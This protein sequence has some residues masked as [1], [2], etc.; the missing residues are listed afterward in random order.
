MDKSFK[1][2]GV[3]FPNEDLVAISKKVPIRTACTLRVTTRQWKDALSD[4]RM[5][6]L[7]RQNKIYIKPVSGAYIKNGT[8]WMWGKNSFGRENPLTHQPTIV[9]VCGRTIH[10]IV[11]GM[12]CTLVLTEDK[13]LYVW[14]DHTHF[15]R[16]HYHPWLFSRDRFLDVCM[17]F[18][19]TFAG[20][21]A[22]G[23]LYLWDG[24]S[25]KA[26]K[27]FHIPETRILK[28]FFMPWIFGFTTEKGVIYLTNYGV[29]I[30]VPTVEEDFMI[31]DWK[32][33][34]NFQI[35]MVVHW[36]QT[37][38]AIV[39]STNGGLYHI[40]IG[41]DGD[42]VGTVNILRKNV[43]KAIYRL[44]IVPR[45]GSFRALYCLTRNGTLC[46]FKRDR[47]DSQKI[48]GY[49]KVFVDFDVTYL[50]DSGHRIDTID[51]KGNITQFIVDF[52]LH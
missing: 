17:G 7:F 14:G 13:Q 9:D 29:D 15:V 8:L 34:L 2:E 51:A 49:G 26:L 35:K 23:G 40:P 25:S 19:D 6:N 28:C 44:D 27:N 39:L 22:D 1:M 41:C 52:S 11:L 21:S 36:E 38:G 18:D 31:V 10:K 42:I 47:Y 5:E 50:A 48:L 45:S 33:Q 3:K 37:G 46:Y 32:E 24:Q 30:A 4:S 43:V 20:V 16:L 12:V